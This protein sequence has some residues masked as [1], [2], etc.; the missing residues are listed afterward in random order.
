VHCVVL[1]NKDCGQAGVKC[2]RTVYSTRRL[3]GCVLA[4]IKEQRGNWS[5]G[6]EVH[7]CCVVLV[8]KNMWSGGEVQR[9]CNGY[10]LDFGSKIWVPAPWWNGC[11]A[12]AAEGRNYFSSD[13]H[14]TYA[15]AR[16]RLSTGLHEKMH[17][18]NTGG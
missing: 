3:W 6:D 4:L 2:M 12:A 9:R 14:P 11:E 16:R 15:I 8:N 10:A 1:A 18:N 7:V 5:S 13:L 17:A